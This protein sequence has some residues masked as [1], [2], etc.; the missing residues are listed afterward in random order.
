ME[1]KIVEPVMADNTLMKALRI[2]LGIE[3]NSED[4][5]EE[6][7]EIKNLSRKATTKEEPEIIQKARTFRQKFEEITGGEK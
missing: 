1:F 3:E 5:T 7:L 6:K 4:V 2:M